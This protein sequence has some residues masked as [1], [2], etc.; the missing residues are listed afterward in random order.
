MLTMH[1]R[2]D[3]PQLFAMRGLCAFRYADP[4]PVQPV[5]TSE[6]ALLMRMAGYSP[7]VAVYGNERII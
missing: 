6:L 4:V 5:K 7:V 2:R 1:A 3:G